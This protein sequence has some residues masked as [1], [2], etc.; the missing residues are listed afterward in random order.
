MGI[1]TFLTT[2]VEVQQSSQ[3]RNAMGGT[4]QVFSTRIAALKCR[5]RPLKQQEIDVNGAMTV[6]SMWRLYCVA[7]SDGTSIEETD[8]IIWTRGG[9]EKTFQVKTIY[10]AGQLNRHMEINV[11][12][13]L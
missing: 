11:F 1:G 3:T 5:L 2:T 6:V 4:A 8:R 9:T 12:E 13:I 10:N 7:D